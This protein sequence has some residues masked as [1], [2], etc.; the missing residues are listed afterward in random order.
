MLAIVFDGLNELFHKPDARNK[1]TLSG[2]IQS[3]NK[4]S[5]R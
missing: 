1:T 3:Y 2:V 4:K 5:N